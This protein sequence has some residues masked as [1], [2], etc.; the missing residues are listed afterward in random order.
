MGVRVSIDVL[1]AP[2]IGGL[3]LRWPD[4][5]GAFFVVPLLE[6]STFWRNAPAFRAQ[7]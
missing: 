4:H 7:H 1:I 5:R 6:F 3:S 2:I